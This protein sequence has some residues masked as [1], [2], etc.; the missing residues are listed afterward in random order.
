VSKAGMLIT[1][2]LNP[3]ATA[4]E[5]GIEAVNHALYGVTDFSKL[6]SFWDL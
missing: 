6:R 2:G 5:A 3:V 1:D 4:V